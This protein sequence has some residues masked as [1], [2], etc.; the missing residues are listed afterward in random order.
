MDIQEAKAQLAYV[1]AVVERAT[2]FTLI[3]PLSAW[4]VGLCGLAAGAYSAWQLRGS[5]AYADYIDSLTWVWIFCFVVS[6]VSAVFWTRLRARKEGI[7]LWN[8][9]IRQGLRH[10][11]T[12]VAVGGILTLSLMSYRFYFLIPGVWMLCY[13]AGLIVSS[14]FSMKEFRLQGALFMFAGAAALWFPVLN[15]FL[16]MATFGIGHLILGTWIYF[17]YPASR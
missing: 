9:A 6:S 12:L 1:Q 17:R 14:M 10:F 16:L 3:S 5:L 4:S 2:Q 15:H 7:P 11:A 8:H 13:G